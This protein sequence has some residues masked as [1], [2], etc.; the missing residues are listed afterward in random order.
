MKKNKVCMNSYL[1]QAWITMI[2][3]YGSSP[4]IVINPELTKRDIEI[5]IEYMHDGFL[6]LN[7]SPV[8]TGYVSIDDETGYLTMSARYNGLEKQSYVP[9]ESIVIVRSDCGSIAVNLPTQLTIFGETNIPTK[10]NVSDVTTAPTN[11]EPAIRLSVREDD[12]NKQTT[13]PK[14]QP[15]VPTIVK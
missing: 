5:P 9:I 10:P 8:A 12:L 15:F 2:N 4:F 1:L 6:T 11:E 13:R 3:Q 14:R 7:V